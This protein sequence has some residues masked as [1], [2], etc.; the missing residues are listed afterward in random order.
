M[1]YKNIDEII[2]IQGPTIPDLERDITHL[3]PMPKVSPN[4]HR[5]CGSRN[6]KTNSMSGKVWVQCFNC[7]ELGPSRS[8][9]ADAIAAW[10]EENK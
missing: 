6:V 10:N 2:E 8:T 4:K 5:K 1:K 9:E 3:R 7:D